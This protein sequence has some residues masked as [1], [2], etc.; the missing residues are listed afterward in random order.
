LL[1]VIVYT[2]LI[3]RN[4]S[5]IFIKFY[6][7]TSDMKKSIN[8]ILRTNKDNY[9]NIDIEIIKNN[10]QN[11][12]T[13]LT[14][15]QIKK[16]KKDLRDS[17]SSL[18][19]KLRNIQD[20]ESKGI[21][22]SPRTTRAIKRLE[23]K[24]TNLQSKI[25]SVYTPNE[26]QNN[27]IDMT[28]I[29]TQTNKILKDKEFR[30]IFNDM[31]KSFIA[32][33]NLEVITSVSHFDQQSS[34]THNI[35]K[36]NSNRELLNKKDDEEIKKEDISNY[37][38]Q[39]HIDYNKHCL[40]YQQEYIDNNIPINLQDQTP[41]DIKY[42][43]IE[44]YKKLHPIDIEPVYT[45]PIINKNIIE[46]IG[47]IIK[48][49]YISLSNVKKLFRSYISQ[50][51]DKEIEYNNSIYKNKIY[52]N[53]DS[54]ID[55][56]KLKPKQEL[57]LSNI[58]SQKNTIIK[59]VYTLDK[60]IKDSKLELEKVLNGKKEREKILEGIERELEEQT[61]EISKYRGEFDILSI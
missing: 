44:Q 29:L 5:N 1:I 41:L 31:N 6:K 21:S 18:N 19:Q 35:L 25:N 57:L 10:Y 12:N 46:N 27:Y 43:E 9:K 39:L 26:N 32:N 16:L 40:Q 56:L 47:V 61:Q 59:D 30:T 23:D 58:T 22:I 2:R 20:K 49:P 52:S 45:K 33:Q 4:A 13:N 17:K 48:K 55:Y 37:L 42:L 38:K 28:L 15:S 34:H 8:H 53:I 54:M 50:I 11:I 7:K 36:I 60:N 24:I 3:M 14:P 51:K